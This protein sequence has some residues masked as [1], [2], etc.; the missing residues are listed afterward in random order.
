MWGI[1]RLRTTKR[2]LNCGRLRSGP[3]LVLGLAH[4]LM[5]G[6]IFVTGRRYMLYRLTSTFA[7]VSLGAVELSHVTHPLWWRQWMCWW[8]RSDD[9]DENSTSAQLASD[10]RWPIIHHR[11]H[12]TPRSRHPLRRRRSATGFAV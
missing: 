11:R 3:G 10:E 8:C 9:A 5:S 2:R 1:S 4:L 6:N 7:L 12:R